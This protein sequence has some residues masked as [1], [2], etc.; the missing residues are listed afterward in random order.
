M[1]K[2]Y[3]PATTDSH[4]GMPYFRNGDIRLRYRIDG[5][6]PPVLVIGGHMQ[7]LGSWALQVKDLKRHFQVVRFDNRGTGFSDAPAGPYT[8][9]Q[10]AEDAAALLDH[11][12]I[13]RA[14]VVGVSMGGMIA[15]HLALLHPERVNRMVLIST[16][17]GFTRP[18]F[19][20]VLRWLARSPAADRWPLRGFMGQL[21]AIAEHDTRKRLKK[22]EAPTLVMAGRNDSLTP[23]RYAEELA[24]GI[25]G[26]ELAV[27]PGTA[28]LMIVQRW[29]DVNRRVIDFLTS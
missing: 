21:G 20:E 16:N 3:K 22:I 26:A 19:L 29:R 23:V 17:A 25:P 24:G 12:R 9:E 13:R 7:P 14:H 4:R 27:V 2:G 6:S 11:L 10:M 28:H 8:M 5:G 15:Q 1:E 18:E